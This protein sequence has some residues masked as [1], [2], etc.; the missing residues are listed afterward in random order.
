MNMTINALD[1]SQKSVLEGLLDDDSPDLSLVYGPPGTGKSHLIVSLLFELAVKNKKVLFVSQNRE[2]LDVIIRKYHDIDNEMGISQSSLKFLDLCLY[3]SDTAQRRVQY[4]RGLKERIQNGINLIPYVP[5][6]TDNPNNEP[7]ALS[8]KS[9]DKILNEAEITERHSELGIDEILASNLEFIRNSNII[10]ATINGI[11]LIDAR[12]VYDVLKKYKQHSSDFR[13]F[14]NPN[15]ELRFINKNNANL[16]ITEVRQLAD[17]LIENSEKCVSINKYCTDLHESDIVTLLNVISKACELNK[18][19]YIN[20]ILNDNIALWD[21]YK[22]LSDSIVN[23]SK[24]NNVRNIKGLMAKEDE[25]FV[26]SCRAK[27]GSSKTVNSLKEKIEYDEFLKNSVK[28]M[29]KNGAPDSQTLVKTFYSIFSSVDIKFSGFLAKYKK[30]KDTD[31]EKLVEECEKWNQ[32]GFFKKNFGQIPEIFATINVKE[33]D[34]VSANIDYIKVFIKILKGTGLTLSEFKKLYDCA[35]KA[36]C[37]KCD[38]AIAK[39]P[40]EAINSALKVR[41]EI[42]KDETITRLSKMSLSDIVVYLD[43]EIKDGERLLLISKENS[44]NSKSVKEIIDIIDKNIENNEI[45]DNIAGSQRKIK[46]YI[47]CDSEADFIKYCDEV[48]GNKTID[49][50]VVGNLL[51]LMDPKYDYDS[52]N[53]DAIY[54]LLSVIRKC[55]NEYVFSN[56]FYSL[57]SYETFE[58]WAERARLIYNYNNLDEFDKYHKHND[59]IAKLK[60]ILG[61]KNDKYIEKYLGMDLDFDSF[62]EHIVYDLNR[63]VFSNIPSDRR[64]KIDT[65]TFFKTYN[66]KLKDSRKSYYLSELR[67]MAISH[68][69]QAKHLSQ[70]LNIARFAGNKMEAIR[71]HTELISES[72]P[73]I[74]ATPAD[75][76]KFLKPEK[77]LFDYVIFDEASQLL[78]GQAIPC[79]FRAKKAVIVGDPHQMPPTSSVAIGA[80]NTN[81]MANAFLEDDEVSIL[82]IVKSMQIGAIHHLKVHYRSK[83]NVL[84]E[85]SRRAI[86][87]EDNINPIIEAQSTAMPLFITDNLETDEEGFRV[88]VERANRY[89]EEN[90]DTTF[91]ILFTR[92]DKSGEM[93]FRKYLEEH[94]EEAKELLQ[95]YE[96]EK[97]LISTITNCQGIMGD[98]TILYIPSYVSPSSMWFFKGAAGAYRRL[99]V[100]ITRQVETLDIVMGD[101]KSKWLMTCQGIINS[102]SSDPN[103]KKSAELLYALLTNAGRQIDE[104][105]L[106]Q[107]LGHNAENIDSPLTQELYDK[108]L[109]YFGDRIGNELKIWCEVGYKIIIPDRESIVKNNYNVGYRIDIGIYSVR[110]KRFILGIE[111]DGATYHSGFY[112]QFSDAQR[113]EILESKGWNL[114]RIWST[115]W[116]YDTQKEFSDLIKV[117]EE[118]L[119]REDNLPAEDSSNIHPKKPNVV[120]YIEDAPL[121]I[122]EK[123]N[124]IHK[125]NNPY[126]QVSYRRG[127]TDYLKEHLR[128]GRPITIKYSNIHSE[129]VIESIPFQS[130]YLKNVTDDY[131]EASFDQKSGVYRIY[132]DLIYAYI[133]KVL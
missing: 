74:I 133:D 69:D 42:I 80:M 9:L 67:S 34:E 60:N 15:N 19:F 99:N 16:S 62:A 132:I 104:D 71:A 35:I 32:K 17:A 124:E 43:R 70:S 109:E 121:D 41:N 117:I 56:G 103:S 61:D 39:K 90:P 106:E 75:V 91:C 51:E 113:Q 128:L 50:K 20:K 98:H 115:N 24:L 1:P 12:E 73:I 44:F 125:P 55:M 96:N 37:E 81:N 105:Y 72:Y 88:V 130:M 123:S 111:M 10:P 21:I 122:S 85:P 78:P 22:S 30:Y 6:N 8:Y 29:I 25:T 110:R 129:S 27:F 118:E 4:I 89:I 38:G 116:L 86:Y 107:M 40:F 97:L 100:A 11:S 46:P 3:L 119:K 64:P 52:I 49:I 7:Y 18:Y 14:N 45:I 58:M 77:E 126:G 102:P 84:F 87:A 13:H 36:K 94:G 92:K 131:I 47:K 57:K 59:F 95:K 82:D 83:Y 5:K 26:E 112:K 114:Y 93:G 127:L 63:E 101:S 23:Y 2:A 54:E 65:S 76:A 28:E 120:D 53:L 33:A 79:I 68:E 48:I 66:K 31:F 108:L